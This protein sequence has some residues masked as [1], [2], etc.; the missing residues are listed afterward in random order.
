MCKSG[1]HLSIDIS[2]E[3]EWDRGHTCGCLK[4]DASALKIV[5]RIEL[6]RW[7]LKW[8]RAELD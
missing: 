4:S 3:H 7:W 1:E 6:G 2:L 5:Q 8:Y